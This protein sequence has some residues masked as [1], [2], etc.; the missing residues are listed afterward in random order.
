MK[1]P[2]MATSGAAILMYHEV[3]ALSKVDALARKTQ[4][5]YIC[6]DDEFEAQIRFMHENDFKMVS[7]SLLTDAISAGDELPPKTVVITFDDGFEG[8]YTFAAPILSK[9]GATATFF[10]VSNRIGDPFMM[11][12][13]QLHTM[14]EAGFEVQSHTAN[15]PLLSTLDSAATLAEFYESKATIEAQLGRRCEY[16]SLPNGDSNP[17]VHEHA[18][19]CGYKGICGSRFGFNEDADAFH[20]DRIA[21]KGGVSIRDFQRIVCREPEILRRMRMRAKFKSTIAAVLGKQRYDKLYNAV[22]RV[23]EQD[24]RRFS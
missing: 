18:L 17:Y 6:T 11:S 20:L 22:Y 19:S 8:N 16:M 21:I 9:Y 2:S 3:T 1:K 5:S 13:N 14:V 12:W 7:L 10:V 24:K 23:E 4:R 15:H